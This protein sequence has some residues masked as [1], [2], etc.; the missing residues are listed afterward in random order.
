M[1]GAGAGVKQTEEEK[2][3]QIQN[4][5]YIDKQVYDPETKTKRWIIAFKRKNERLNKRDDKL[6]ILRSAIG[7]NLVGDR[8]DNYVDVIRQRP[9]NDPYDRTPGPSKPRHKYDTTDNFNPIMPSK[10]AIIDINNYSNPTLAVNLTDEQYNR[11]RKDP[12][13]KA[14][15][16]DVIRKIDVQTIPYGILRVKAQQGWAAGRNTKGTG[17]FFGNLDTG[18][19]TAHEDL[20]F[21]K[22]TDGRGQGKSFISGDTTL[23]NTIGHGTHTTGTVVA[24]DNDVGVIGVAPDARPFICKVAAN[25]A[26]TLTGS[27]L[28]AARHFC[29]GY[30]INVTNNSYGGYTF[31]TS[32]DQD[33]FDM[34]TKF[35]MITSCSA[36]NDNKK[37]MN[38]LFNSRQAAT[39]QHY[40][41]GYSSCIETSAFDQAD[42]IA[43]FS[44]CGTKTEFVGPGVQ[45]LSTLPGNR[46]GASDGTSMSCPHITGIMCMAYSNLLRDVCSDTYGLKT[47][48]SDLCRLAVRKTAD[49]FGQFSDRSTDNC[50]AFGVPQSDAAANELFTAHAVS[51]TNITAALVD[52]L[53]IADVTTD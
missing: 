10:Q 6:L 3:E 42:H 31:V 35:L 30:Q 12:N 26:I 16:P 49:K 45:V 51:L 40:P 8:A 4:P 27:A 33:F 22:Y 38:G 15:D 34:Q 18:C 5:N 36:G 20:P 50:I 25:G 28:I 47:L 19:D 37:T 21:G 52:G 9:E 29:M 48:A 32:E 41:S 24:Q 17:V 44:N 39:N 13:V 23:T 43:S 14:V 2:R 1:I 11:I 7:G 46:Y 53:V